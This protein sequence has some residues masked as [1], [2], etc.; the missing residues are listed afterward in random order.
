[1]INNSFLEIKN[2]EDLEK[3]KVKICWQIVNG[4][5]QESGIW[6]QNWKNSRKCCSKA[7]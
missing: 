7:N 4:L 1:M 5:N 3:E 6:S 2:T